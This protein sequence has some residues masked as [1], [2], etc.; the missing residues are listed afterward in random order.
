MTAR[1]ISAAL[2]A[3][4]ALVPMLAAA[5]S[6]IVGAPPL[7]VWLWLTAAALEI[8]GVST[9]MTGLG[10]AL[11]AVGE[12]RGGTVGGLLIAVVGA[13]I[14]MTGRSVL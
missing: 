4:L 6:L 8:V 1:P 5:R 14:F 12:R 7:P 13:V 10:V 11:F 3:G 2:A 9:V